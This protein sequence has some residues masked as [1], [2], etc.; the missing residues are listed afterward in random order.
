MTMKNEK[1]IEKDKMEQD[2]RKASCGKQ[3]RSINNKAR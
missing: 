1:Q 2:K 3:R